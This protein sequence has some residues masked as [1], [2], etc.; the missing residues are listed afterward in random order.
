MGPSPTSRRV[1]LTKQAI[2]SQ[3]TRMS[4]LRGIDGWSIRDIAK[5]LDVVPS[6]IYHYFPN[7]DFLCDEV[8]DQVCADIAVPDLSLD[9]KPWFTQLAH[10]IRPLLL[11]YHGVT[12]RLVRGKITR[13]F[14]PVLDAA[15]QKL[16][17]AGFGDQT[18]FAYAIITNTAINAIGTRNLRSTHQTGERHDLNV[19]LQRFEPLMEE[20]PGLSYTVKNYLK[21]LSEP[22]QEEALS[23]EYFDLIVAVILDGVEHVLLP[24]ATKN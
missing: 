4:E 14:L 16:F 2:I 20:S 24:R 8:V 15:H 18:A 11:R 7:K 5:E 9:W 19:M 1:G 12:D 3:A 17:E 21:P 22:G 13:Q 23:E 6:V 10:N